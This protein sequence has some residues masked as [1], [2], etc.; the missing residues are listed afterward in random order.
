M[1]TGLHTRMVDGRQGIIIEPIGTQP[2]A[3]PVKWQALGQDPILKLSE[4]LRN[5][6]RGSLFKLTPEE[7]QALAALL[8]QAGNAV[9]LPAVTVRTTIRSS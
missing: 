9:N 5:N 8:T 7:A 3:H 2:L 4:P 1:R 6:A